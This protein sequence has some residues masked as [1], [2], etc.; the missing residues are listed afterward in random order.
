MKRREFVVV[1]A[2]G[3]AAL[4]GCSGSSPE[5]TV[6]NTQTVEP[7]TIDVDAQREIGEDTYTIELENSGI[8]GTIIVEM[9]WYEDG[10]KP[11]SPA[12][13][14]STYFNSGERRELEFTVDTPSWADRYE[15]STQ[16]TRFAADIR[17]SGSGGDVDVRLY[18]Q[19]S[20][21]VVDEKTVFIE[22]D[23]TQMV[24]FE[25]DHEFEEGYGIA[26]RPA[27]N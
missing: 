22:A 14:Q 24:D 10:A 6:M 16:G 7:R 20:E 26:A 25:T 19:P 1:S 18:D 2:A 27:D 3:I 5:I 12:S 21:T 23:A 4:A 11:P 9:F 15:F 8:S 13:S 17:N